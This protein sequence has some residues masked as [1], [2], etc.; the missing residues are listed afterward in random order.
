[1]SMNEYRNALCN[2]AEKDYPD[3]DYCNA[4]YIIHRTNNLNN[5]IQNN[6]FQ[7]GNTI[8]ENLKVLTLK[9]DIEC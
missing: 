3:K 8:S 4:I 7:Y 6:F 1:M 9:I 2:F 5:K